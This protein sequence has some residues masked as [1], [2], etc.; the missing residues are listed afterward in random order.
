M[1]GAGKRNIRKDIK[2]PGDDHVPKSS[3][4]NYL[5]VTIILLFLHYEDIRV[6]FPKLEA[7]C[8]FE[9]STELKSSE[10]QL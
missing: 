10:Y 8:N 2:V 5:H 3:Q 1:G 6:P 7:E 4:A 9:S